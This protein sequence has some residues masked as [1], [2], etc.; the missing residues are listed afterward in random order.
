MEGH[1]EQ[2]SLVEKAVTDSMATL[3]GDP[4][5]VRSRSVVAPLLHCQKLELIYQLLR[6]GW[7]ACNTVVHWNPGDRTFLLDIHRATSYFAA[8]LDH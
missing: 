2:L 5:P 4:E 7:Q 8:L 3:L 6:T 1:D